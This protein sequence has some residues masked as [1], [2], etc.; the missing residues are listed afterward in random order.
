MDAAKVK[1]QAPVQP[2][3]R[4]NPRPAPSEHAQN[5]QA[6]PKPVQEAKPKP[7]V[8]GQGQTIGQRLNVTA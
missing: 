8:N 4:A 5:R 6:E 1:P 7:T 2:A 3:A